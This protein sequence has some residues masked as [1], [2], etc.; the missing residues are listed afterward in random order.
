MEG[1][2]PEQRTGSAR[3]RPIMGNSYRAS[4]GQTAH[5]AHDP[6]EALWDGDTVHNWFVRMVAV[7]DAPDGRAIWRSS[8]NATTALRPALSPP[9]PAGRR[10]A[11]L[12]CRLTS[13][14]RIGLH[15]QHHHRPQS[16]AAAAD[17]NLRERQFRAL[18]NKA[19]AVSR[20]PDSSQPNIGV[21][22]RLRSPSGGPAYG[23]R[24][25][26]RP[27]QRSWA[28]CQNA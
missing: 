8:P 7:L 11:T 15:D 5:V 12:A 14:P 9:R 16:T 2:G 6:V 1:A 23:S 4:P 24:P 27:V 10:R 21:T 3:A 28:S 18:G 19:Y 22:L 20:A 13:L 26:L 25:G 17:R